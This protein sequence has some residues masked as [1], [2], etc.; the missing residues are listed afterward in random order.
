[1][2]PGSDARREKKSAAFW[3]YLGASRPKSSGFHC[4]CSDFCLF[5]REFAAPQTLWDEARTRALARTHSTHTQTYAD[6]DDDVLPGCAEE[7]PQH[8]LT[9]GKERDS[10]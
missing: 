2:R 9:P 5:T 4:C 3:V 1:M 6:T 7:P 10:G 8:Y